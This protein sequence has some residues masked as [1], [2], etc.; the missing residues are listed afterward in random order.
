MSCPPY[1][2]C[3][4]HSYIDKP[5]KLTIA[6]ICI[7]FFLPSSKATSHQHGFGTLHHRA[8]LYIPLRR[9]LYPLRRDRRRTADWKTINEQRGIQAHYLPATNRSFG[10]GRVNHF[11][12]SGGG[13]YSIDTG[14]NSSATAIHLACAALRDW[15]C[16][17]A[18]VGG[19]S[20][21][22]IPE[23]FS[24]FSFGGF[25]SPTGGCKTFSE[26]ADGYCR[27][28]AVGTVILN[29]LEDAFS[30]D[31]HILGVISAT[32]RNSNAGEGSI[33]YPGQ[34]AQVRLL[35]E[36]LGKSGTDASEIGFV[37]IHG[38]GTI[39]GD[40][41]EMNTVKRV[42]ADSDANRVQPVYVGAVKANIGHGEA[43]AGITS[44]IKALLML[45][46]DRMPGQP[47]ELR[48]S[49][50]FAGF[51][52][53]GIQNSQGDGSLIPR[54]HVDGTR[55]IIVNS[56]DAAGGNTSILLGNPRVHKVYP[57]L[58]P[59]THQVVTI[60]GRTTQ[61]LKSNIDRLRRH[62]QQH[63]RRDLLILLIQQLSGAHTMVTGRHMLWSLWNS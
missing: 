57:G 4:L 62:L 20:I 43:A 34:T 15:K 61:S 36:L 29:R 46:H 1:I 49:Q 22:V 33:T 21:C 58:D 54:S 17:M 26:D 8:N 28:E 19:G 23:Y 13:S 35:T 5:F 47:G 3:Q 12:G 7:P 25:I 38:T 63:P 55:K 53:A 50:R 51:A 41:V 9:T 40:L 44:L 10:P 18:I 39:A 2:T 31:D 52:A 30:A 27:G 24:G 42:L 6:T 11:F 45:K 59:R 48:L 14:C 32:V 37:E 16:D 56:F 60:S